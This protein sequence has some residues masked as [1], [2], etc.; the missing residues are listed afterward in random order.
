MV[1]IAARSPA[2]SMAGPEVTF[3]LTPISYDMMAASV[4]LPNPG[5]PY[6]STWSR[7]SSLPRAA[8]MKM[9]MLSLT[10]S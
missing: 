5:G 9:D 2:R 4:V 7:G 6:S 1:R 3:S 10:R 8:S